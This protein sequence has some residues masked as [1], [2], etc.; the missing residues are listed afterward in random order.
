MLILIIFPYLPL[1]NSFILNFILIT[2]SFCYIINNSK[3]IFK[4]EN[5]NKY[6]NVLYIYVHMSQKS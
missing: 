3:Y 1:P 5:N 4:Q 6:K 2:Y